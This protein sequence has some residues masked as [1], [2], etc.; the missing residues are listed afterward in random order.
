[1]RG[2]D[3]EATH[4]AFSTAVEY[5][6]DIRNRTVILQRT[7]LYPYCLAERSEASGSCLLCQFHRSGAKRLTG[8]RRVV[9]RDSSARCRSLQNDRRGV[10]NPSGARDHRQQ[11]AGA[12]SCSGSWFV[13]LCGCSS[14][15]QRIE[16]PRSGP[17][18][19]RRAL[20]Q[21]A[22]SSSVIATRANACHT[23]RRPSSGG[24][25]KRV[26]SARCA[27]CWRWVRSSAW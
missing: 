9:R 4:D 2:D 15:T 18:G 20:R 21:P 5:L 17:Y 26:P 11:R 6:D 13:R 7:R 23:A 24:C 3:E 27:L 1:M 25:S 8:A 10:I 14:N 22:H 19:R 16:R 12:Q